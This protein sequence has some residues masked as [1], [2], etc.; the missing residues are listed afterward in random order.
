MSRLN[1][2]RQSIRKPVYNDQAYTVLPKVSFPSKHKRIPEKQLLGQDTPPSSKTNAPEANKWMKSDGVLN[3]GEVE[4][5]LS[6]H[7]PQ[8]IG[9]VSL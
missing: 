8:K 9:R 1:C 6:V 2:A 7:S 3:W 4:R 5:L